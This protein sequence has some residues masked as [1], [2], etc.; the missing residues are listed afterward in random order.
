MYREWLKLR[1]S[2][3]DTRKWARKCGIEEARLYEITKLR[4]QFREILQQNDLIPKEE[5][6]EWHSLSS[7]ERRIMVG[8]KRKLNELKKRAVNEGKKTKVI[9]YNFLNVADFRVSMN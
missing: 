3:E 6:R 9:T 2:G 1:T 7:R 8:E 5:E 4:R